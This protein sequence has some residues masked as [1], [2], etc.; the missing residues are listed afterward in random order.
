M[1]GRLALSTVTVLAIIYL[2]PLVL[3]ALSS[4]F[5]SMPSPENAGPARFLTGVLVTKFG[6][7][8]AFVGVFWL[9]RATWEN[10]WLVY[11]A[12]WFAMFA[13]SEVGDAVSGRSTTGEAVVGVVSEAVYAPLSAW[14][15]YEMLASL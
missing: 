8:V 1:T 5:I 10:R 6:T 2:V 9:S 11:A 3:Y 13:G 14:V 4:R 7:A 12:L 15:V